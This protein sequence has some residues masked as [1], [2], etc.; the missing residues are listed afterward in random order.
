MQT[1]LLH[2]NVI[3]WQTYDKSVAIVICSLKVVIFHHI[4]TMIMVIEA[5]VTICLRKVIRDQKV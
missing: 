4:S 3:C 1:K 5:G 2:D